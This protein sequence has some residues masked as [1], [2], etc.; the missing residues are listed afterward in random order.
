MGLGDFLSGI[1]GTNSSVDTGQSAPI[2]TQ[3][4]TRP[5]GTGLDN[6]DQ[7]YRGQ[8]TLASQLQALA[9]GQGPNPVASMLQAA[10]GQNAAQAAGTFAN[11]RSLSPAMAARISSMLQANTGQQAANQAATLQAQQQIQAQQNLSGLYD[12]MGSQALGLYGTAEQAQSGQNQSINEANR[13]NAGIAAGNQQASEGIIGGLMGGGGAALQGGGKSGASGAS[14]AG[15]GA[16]AAYGGLID[17]Y[18]AGGV[19]T[20]PQP[21]NPQSFAGK[22]LSGMGQSMNTQGQNPLTSGLTSLGSGIGSQI[23]KRRDLPGKFSSGGMP[24]NLKSGGGVPGKATVRGDSYSNDTIPAV[25][26]PKEIVIPR[27]VTMGKNPGTNSKKFVEAV[28]AHKKM[29]NKK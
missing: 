13:V 10:Q 17:R 7:T 16:A 9:N 4:F 25:L 22:F 20:P 14:G 12:K 28:L 2:T 3:D 11:N 21:G 29:G 24:H 1:L 27:S 19:V 5:I 8:Q 23:N 26:S 6:Y 15:A 18:A